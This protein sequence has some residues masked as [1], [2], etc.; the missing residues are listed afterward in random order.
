[1]NE[2]SQMAVQTN[3]RRVSRDDVQTAISKAIGAGQ[4]TARNAAPPTLA[5]AGVVALGLLLIA[6]LLGRR[7]GRSDSAVVEIRRL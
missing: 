4:D 1:M 2:R 3:G 7:G 5:I 6:Y